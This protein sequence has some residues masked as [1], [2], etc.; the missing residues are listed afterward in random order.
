MDCR[1]FRANHLAFL[2]DTLVE[3]GLVAMQRHLAECA[4]CSTHDQAVRR[5]LVLLR[6][7]PAIE[8]SAD[9][10]TRLAAR[11]R[12]ERVAKERAAIA[13]RRVDPL[14]RAPR[15][16]PF[17]AAAA[18]VVMAGTLVFGADVLR[19]GP[20]PT[21][22]LEPVIATRPELVPSPSTT[23]MFV[24]AASAGMTL[25]PAA[26]LVEQAPAHFAESEMRLVSL[27]K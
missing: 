5:G 14:I 18:S 7:M 20:A 16:G 21:L 15:F 6:N 2:D 19:R 11:L 23:P 10:G 24:A 8:P 25:W 26:L 12:A 27:T 3:E 9:F 1:T 22:A 17:A 4:H 13:A